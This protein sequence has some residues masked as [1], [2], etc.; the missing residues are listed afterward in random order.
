MFY[1]MILLSFFSVGMGQTP[2][3]QDEGI[4]LFKQETKGAKTRIT[5]K[6]NIVA[7]QEEIL[8]V[9]LEFNGHHRWVPRLKSSRLLKEFSD[10]RL[11]VE[12]VFDA[13]WPMVDRVFI[14][15]G[16]IKKQKRAFVILG[17]GDVFPLGQ[18]GVITAQIT[19]YELKLIR[20][21]KILTNCSLS[22]VFD[23]K[24]YIPFW[25]TDYIVS[26][27]PMEF[28]KLLRSRVYYPKAF[29]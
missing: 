8:N 11:H 29:K 1:V 22:Y 16:N 28:F 3:I 6:G 17:K 19:D 14:L 2:L 10:G 12:S 27:W 9:L 20:K 23:S 26:K 13:P 24:G 21:G 18:K 7:S 4:S 25:I 5:V 15:E